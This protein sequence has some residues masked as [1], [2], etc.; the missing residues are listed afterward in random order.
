MKM[1][2]SHGLSPQRISQIAG[3]F[4]V[5]PLLGLIVVGLFMAKSEHL[6]EKKY[7][8]RTSLSQ[9]FGLEPGAPVVISGL[10]VG[11]VETVEFNDRGAID[12]RLNVRQRYQSMVREDSQLAV[13]KSGLLVGQTQVEI[14]SGTPTK[15]ILPDGAMITAIEPQDFKQMLVEFKP[16]IESVKQALLR[17]DSLSKD[18][19]ATVQTGNRT[20]GNVEVATQDLPTLVASVQKTVSSVERTASSVERTAAALPDVTRSVRKTLEVVDGIA[21]DVRGATARLPGITAA[22]QDAVNNLK[23][24]T[25]NLK[26][27]SRQASPLIRTAH[28]TLEDV[29]T[30]V[31]GAKQTFPVSMMVANAGPPPVEQPA[32]RLRSL[33]GDPAGR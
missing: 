30:I 25:A 12:V 10:H 2:Y 9:S 4:V 14:T 21:G 8:L 6:F 26:G 23:A 27:V 29:Q 13:G 3:L 24:T 11:Q 20:L 16:A 19:Q 18:I 17:L 15:P 31:R 1:H 22:A 33:R 7:R 28:A 5:V 32:P